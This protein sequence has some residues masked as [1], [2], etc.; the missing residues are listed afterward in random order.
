MNYVNHLITNYENLKL[1]DNSTFWMLRYLKKGYKSDQTPLNNYELKEVSDS[2]KVN[3][4]RLQHQIPTSC[5]K[6]QEL[7]KTPFYPKNFNLSSLINSQKDSDNSSL[8]INQLKLNHF[9]M[10]TLDSSVQTNFDARKIWHLLENDTHKGYRSLNALYNNINMHFLRKERL[11][12]KLKYSRTP[13]YD[14]VS[15]GAAALLAAFFGF[16]ILEKFGFELVDSGDFWYL[17]MYVGV[18]VIALKALVNTMVFDLISTTNILA[19]FSPKH[20][21]NFYFNLIYII[22]KLFK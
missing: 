8:D 22:I 11:Y 20:I 3:V 6:K 14:I 5:L 4:V 7:Y 19:I 21:F 15:G 1:Q 12:T 13:S 10:T 17:V 2:F 9:L 16:L 18:L